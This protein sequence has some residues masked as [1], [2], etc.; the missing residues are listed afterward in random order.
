[1][2]QLKRI[3]IL[4]P[5]I[6]NLTDK[7]WD[8][9]L[10]KISNTYTENDDYRY[11]INRSMEISSQEMQDLYKKIAHEK[12]KL[13]SLMS[14]GLCVVNNSFQIESIN[15]E[16]LRI[17]QCDENDAIGKYLQDIITIYDITHEEKE[18]PLKTI[19][20]EA[21]INQTFFDIEFASIKTTK[22]NKIPV[23]ISINTVTKDKKIN[24]ALV[25]IRD[26]TER[27]LAEEKLHEA[28]NALEVSRDKHRYLA[29]FDTLTNLANRTMFD[30]E[31]NKTISSSKLQG[32]NFALLYIDIDNFKV[33][34]DSFGHEIGDTLLGH[35]ADRLKKCLRKT[36]FIARLGGD[37]FS[38]ILN[39][40]PNPKSAGDKAHAIIEIMKKSFKLKSTTLKVSVSI[41]I[42][43]FPD[44]GKN[45]RTL[46]RNADIAMYHAKKEGKNRF[47]FFTKELN[48]HYKRW[49]DIDSGLKQAI[50]QRELELHYQPIYNLETNEITG[51]ETLLRWHSKML[52]TVSN[53]E[54]IPIAEETNT[55]IPIGKWVL[56]TALAQ[57][58]KWL[59]ISKKQIRLTINIAAEQLLYSNFIKLLKSTVTQLE[60]PPELIE[61]ELTETAVMVPT[62]RLES[63]INQLSAN[64]F[65]ISIDDFGTGYFSISHIQRLPI[66]T[67]KIDKSFVSH[68]ISSHRDTLIVKSLFNLAKTLKLNIVAEGVETKQQLDFL[69]ENHC[70]EAQGFY[71]DRPMNAEKVIQLIS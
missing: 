14:N 23:S 26:M 15:E 44:A 54:Y 28:I 9:L 47:Q 68:V 31:L 67:V 10:L 61:I 29:Y 8:N 33:I 59:T 19:S 64:H 46:L 60:L 56:L 49:Y 12:E 57:F 43:S 16:A 52:G 7:Q 17:M 39:H 3:G 2:R 66:D 41:G 30:L 58:K 40:I 35:V 34:N 62:E 71:L 21:P 37:E 42:A 65:R 4:D 45:A 53:D 1:M 51:F 69:K 25:I 22:S 6:L 27:A 18:I 36:D 24:G 20:L 50:E 13:K 70:T 38:I 63:T 11:T 55:I 48:I 32:N 5:N